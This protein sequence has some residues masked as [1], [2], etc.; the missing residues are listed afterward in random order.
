MEKYNTQNDTQDHSN[1]SLKGEQLG[2]HYLQPITIQAKSTNIAASAI[3]VSASMILT[4][5]AL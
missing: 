1:Q 2:S 5:I 3:G 4:I